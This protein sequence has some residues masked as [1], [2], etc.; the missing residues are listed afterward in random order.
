MSD[1]IKVSRIA[2]YAHHGLHPEEARLGQRF[3]VSLDCVLDLS[4][5]ARNDDWHASVCY[6]ELTERAT[7]VT[8]DRRFRT[9]EGLA[10]AIATDVLATFP[11]IDAVTVQVEKPGAPVP[12]IIDGVMV[13]ITRRRRV[14]S[15]KAPS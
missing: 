13:E 6:A 9:I 2:I 4:E 5:A 1:R 14:A 15:E 7:R 12:A 3:F 10:D 11:L 8:L